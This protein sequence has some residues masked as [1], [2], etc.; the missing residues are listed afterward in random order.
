MK[1]RSIVAQAMMEGPGGWACDNGIL[2]DPCFGRGVRTE[3]E[4][5]ER[6]WD[7]SYD[8]Q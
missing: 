7:R 6:K 8:P 4:Y 2:G 5:V 3:G 1:L